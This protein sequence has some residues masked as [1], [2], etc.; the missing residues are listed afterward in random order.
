MADHV[1]NL[2]RLT[3]GRSPPEG[4]LYLPRGPPAPRRDGSRGAVDPNEGANE[5]QLRLHGCAIAASARE[6]REAPIFDV[7]HLSR[8]ASLEV[9]HHFDGPYFCGPNLRK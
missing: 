7:N 5:G 9:K 8:R 4:M 3:S 2:L 1:G 6:H